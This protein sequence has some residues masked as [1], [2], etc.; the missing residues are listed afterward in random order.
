VGGNIA[1]YTKADSGLLAQALGIEN[2]QSVKF[3][4]GIYTT[5]STPSGPSAT[6]TAGQIAVD[7]N[8]IY[9]CT[10]ENAWKR[11]AISSGGW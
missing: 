5:P 9:V 7:A 2:D 8:Y 10:A 6:G 4:G 11:V 3:F 1:I